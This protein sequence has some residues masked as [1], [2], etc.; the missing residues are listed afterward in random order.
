MRVR[1]P[2]PALN[3]IGVTEVKIYNTLSKKKEEF[4]PLE[5]SKVRIY[6]CGPTV[7]DFSHIGHARAA[8]SFDIIIRYLQFSGFEPKVI[9]NFTDIDDKMIKRANQEGITIYKLADRFIKQYLKDM[10]A[11]NVRR[12]S[13]YPRATENIPDMMKFIEA[14]IERGF[15]YEIEGSVY[16]SINKF[17]NYGKLSHKNLEE[18]HPSEEEGDIEKKDPR[19]FALWKKS[20][21][22]EPYWDSPWGPGRPG[23]HIECSTMSMKYLG[24]TFD[25]HGGGSDLIFP[26]HENEIA[27]SEALTGKSFANYF[28]HNNFVKVNQEKM[29]KSLGNFQTIDAVLQKYAPMAVR[30]LLISTHY[31]SPIDFNEDQIIQAHQSY[32]KFQLALAISEQLNSGLETSNRFTNEL[33]EIIEK[34][35]KEFIEAMDD[36]FSTPRAIASINNLVRYI[37]GLPSNK[38][39]IK[40]E[41][42]QR[43][44]DLLLELGNVL[45]LVKSPQEDETDKLVNRLVGFVLELRNEAREKKQYGVADRIRDQ[46]KKLGITLLDYPNATIWIK[47]L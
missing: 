6:V 7:Y 9:I 40:P 32:K 41:I 23:W 2:S 25:I 12:A 16:F 21:E 3:S 10:D 19:D 33:E 29:S 26:H 20:K 18:L 43:A 5:E 39:R 31:R 42:L 35:R 37:N 15:A 45:G 22:N 24:E 34:T 38:E 14:L 13:F 4:V 1:A 27:Q 36:D 8:I 46:L 11:L 47:E 28:I 44:R 30:F 17:K